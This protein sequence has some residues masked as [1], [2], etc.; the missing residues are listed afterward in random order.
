MTRG[1]ELALKKKHELY[2]KSISRNGSM[3][4]LQKYRKYRNEFN[5]PKSLL[6]PHKTKDLWEVISNII[7]KNKHRGSII[8]HITVNGIKT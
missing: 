8:S 4:D 7:G 2:K 3:E 5:R 6:C 1:I